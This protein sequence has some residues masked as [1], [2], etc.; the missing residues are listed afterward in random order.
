MKISKKSA[1]LLAAALLVSGAPIVANANAS[2]DTYTY[3]S[4]A[5]I[6]KGVLT[7]GTA[8]GPDNKTVATGSAVTTSKNVDKTGNVYFGH[9][10][11]GNTTITNTDFENNEIECDGPNSGAVYFYTHTADAPQHEVTITDSNFNN[12]KI[13][14]T[15]NV[16]NTYSSAKAGAMLVKGVK[17]DLNNV[18]FT[19]NEANA[20]QNSSSMGGAIYMDATLNSPNNYQAI[21]NF[22]VT[23][24]MTYSGNKVSG[25]STYGDSYG[26]Y[27]HKTGGGFLFMDRWSTANFNISE[28]AELKIGQDGVTD[29]LTDSIASTVAG[30]SATYS[31]VINKTGKGVLTVNGSMSDYHGDLNVQ[32]GTMNVNSAWA[33]DST[34][35]VSKDA[36]LNVKALTLNTQEAGTIDALA[37]GGSTTSKVS[38]P[39]KAGSLTVQSGATVTADTITVNG[40]AA[41]TTATGSKLTANN[42]TA[43][44]GTKVSLSGDTTINK[45]LTANGTTITLSGGSDTV[46]S[47]GGNIVTSTVGEGNSAVAG[48]VVL[49]GGKL[50]K[51]DIGST[52]KGSLVIAGTGIL[53]TTS[54][55]IYTYAASE[56][57]QDSGK[58]KSQNI[59][60]TAGTLSLTDAKYTLAYAKA[61]KAALKVQTE[62]STTELVM[63]GDLVQETGE[64]TSTM[65]IDTIVDHASN[66][67]LD[68]VEATAEKN[69]LIGSTEVKDGTDVGG[70]TVE[71]QTAKGFSVAALD[72]KKSDDPTAKMGVVITNA[73]AVTL[74]GTAGGSVVKVVD[75]NGKDTET[76]VKVV[77][78]TTGTVAGATA[79]NG[80]LTIG[81]TI[82]EVKTK[83]E[84][85][86]DVVLNSEST[87]K[88]NG[89]TKITNSVTLNK[90]VVD[91]KEGAKLTT[92][93]MT[94][95]E[96][97]A[98]TGATE[99]T[100]KV[101]IS[102]DTVLSIGS[103]DKAGELKVKDIAG[104]IVFLDPAYADSVDKGS[105]LALT[106]EESAESV[107]LNTALVAGHNS[108]VSVGA[109]LSDA[110][111]AFAKTG[112]TWEKDVSAAAYIGKNVTL[113]DTGSLTVNG[114]L[115]GDSGD[116]D[117]SAG[118][119]TFAK[120]S[121]LMVD[122]T[123]ALSTAAISDVKTATVDKGSKLYIDGAVKGETYKILAGAEGSTISAEWEEGNIIA[124]NN[125]LKF[126]TDNTEN[127]FDVKSSLQ[128][129]ADVYGK[130]VITPDVFD[131]ALEDASSDAAKFVDNAVRTSVNGTTNAQ[132]SA[133][134]SAA[135]MSELAGAA[136]G[137]YAVSNLL[138]D[139]VADHMSISNNLTH[140]KD[141]WAKYIHTKEDIDGLDIAGF[142]SSYKAQ[143]NGIVV[144]ADLYH[145]E[146][147]T[148]GVALTYAD[149]NISGNTLS[150]YTKNDAE[151]YGASIYG[152]IRNGDTA[153]IGDISYLHSKNDITQKNSGMNITGSE[154]S[155][156]F[157]IG[158]RAE[159]SIKAG[160]GELV[161]YAGLR[162]MHLSNGSYTNSL[163]MSYDG[164]D[165][166]LW[167]LPVGVKY[168]VNSV[169]GGWTL[170]PIVE[171]GYVWNMGDRDAKETVSLGGV[172]NAFSYDV[173]D[174][175]SYIGHLGFEAEKDSLTY[176]VGYEYQKGSSVKANRWMASVNY[177]F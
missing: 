83:Y 27:Y 9:F 101:T 160:H 151:Y 159:Q 96:S 28:G 84:L 168:S 26:G 164:D 25:N 2:H 98:I 162:Y 63:T 107:T 128:K 81:N 153:V 4:D 87:L 80:T 48:K 10:F 144:G 110:D 167:L 21:A 140:D 37:P 103:T 51:N 3:G 120:N 171:I 114:D 131:K 79:A 54:D 152:G 86:G 19:G 29:T 102:S 11:W 106:G 45:D 8:T 18:G 65:D 1:A 139:A 13:T 165:M 72:L 177:R 123:K 104:G 35:V 31:N 73:Q 77:I 121:L 175:G 117:L 134:D 47:I 156:A 169:H 14:T 116:S 38:V 68:K 23:K 115:K 17:V 127:K 146:K 111:E 129:V 57:A 145:S 67:T 118:S 43:N 155:N 34:T 157:S 109:E 42:V 52:L 122:G 60:Y 124:D 33:S 40:K 154:K 132:I 113:G 69:L 174:S 50:T 97:S 166:N 176:G 138:T 173:T 92:A 170:R 142:G 99:V 64:T 49:S 150:A 41:V 161:P 12:N 78:G 6:E 66:V 59:T 88:V 24:D 16:A 91:V 56:T 76:D 95:S 61:A 74:G 135:A 100:E 15:G 44:A 163:G 20:S 53:S 147:A 7:K 93:N 90:G 119:V 39:E 89:Q 141:I 55:Q 137:T 46:Y 130:A 62:G 158:V 108:R 32:A 70:V 143:Y 148:V 5:T 82:S 126:T 112:L 71:Q 94:V 75:E 58:V 172:S 36:T 85:K 125:L 149:G 30:T 22:N 133:L 105:G 136:H